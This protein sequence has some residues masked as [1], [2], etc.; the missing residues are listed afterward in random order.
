MLAPELK[1]PVASERSCL[2]K[3]SAV[4]LMAAGKFP[5]SPKA[6]TARESIKPTIEA[7]N[8]VKPTAAMILESK[9]PAGK[10]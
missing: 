5:A 2:G 4:A 1:I 10:A 7:G 3:Y 6:R 8:T 9:V